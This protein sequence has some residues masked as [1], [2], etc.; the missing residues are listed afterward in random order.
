MSD[1]V[2]FPRNRYT[3]WYKDQA[4]AVQKIVR[5]PPEKLHDILP[6]DIVELTNTKNDDWTE[7]NDY[8]VKH[9]SWKNPNVL[10]LEKSDG[11]STFVNY[12]DVSVRD[13]I[14]RD[15]KIIDRKDDPISSRYL[16][17]P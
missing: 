9:I 1:P 11:E 6:T 3:V 4:G 5:R 16:G 15:G 10:Q 12:T 13:R 2:Q 14:I 8:S 7:G 17:W